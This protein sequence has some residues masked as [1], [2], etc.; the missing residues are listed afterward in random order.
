MDKRAGDYATFVYVLRGTEVCVFEY[1]YDVSNL[2]EEGVPHVGGC[3][4]LTQ[5]Y[6]LHN[7]EQDTKRVVKGIIKPP[8]GLGYLILEYDEE[9]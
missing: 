5:P 3:V 2:T 7:T 9:P 1:H 4:P 8:A 6:Y